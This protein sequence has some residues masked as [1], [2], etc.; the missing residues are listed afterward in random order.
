MVATV[1]EKTERNSEACSGGIDFEIRIMA[2]P[3]LI[4]QRARERRAW[5]SRD[6]PRRAASYRSLPRIQRLASPSKTRSGFG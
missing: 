4:A 2:V 6:P 3:W 1:E 5:S